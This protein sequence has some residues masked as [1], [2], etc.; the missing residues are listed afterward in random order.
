[1]T[2]LLINKK[3]ILWNMYLPNAMNPKSK[4][5][6]ILLAIDIFI[7]A[8]AAL[9]ASDSLPIA[10]YPQTRGQARTAWTDGHAEHA[11]CLT[12]A[13]NILGDT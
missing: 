3:Y 1:M 6:C 5:S 2:Q 4:P 11:Q 9:R 12:W 7:R 13:S 8:T 10:L